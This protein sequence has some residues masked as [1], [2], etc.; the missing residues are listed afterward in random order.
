MTIGRTRLG[1]QCQGHLQTTDATAD[2]L[3]LEVPIP[4][5]HSATVDVW[6]TAVATTGER[7]AEHSVHSVSRDGATATY[8]GE[9]SNGSYSSGAGAWVTTVDCTGTGLRVRVT[10]EAA[11]TIEWHAVASFAP[12][13]VNVPIVWECSATPYDSSMAFTSR[14]SA[15]ST[16]Y[17]DWGDGSFDAVAGTGGDVATAHNYASAGH[18]AIRVSCTSHAAM[19]RLLAQSNQ[20]AGTVPIWSGARWL[21]VYSNRLIGDIPDVSVAA[22]LEYFHTSF[23]SGIVGS[24]PS[25]AGNASLQY[26]QTYSCGLSG[27]IPSLTANVALLYFRVYSNQLTGYTAS[28]IAATCTD[29]QVQNNLL[30]EAAVDQIMADFLVGAAGRPAAGTISLGGS[31]NAPLSAAGLASK[32]AFLA[33]RPGWAI[34]HN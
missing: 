20:I 26:W 29:F 9:V 25:L 13:A 7:Y 34:T 22:S 23:Q 32:A 12:S 24:I 3:L 18:Y 11:H 8:V 17:Y 19:L 21:S 30:T 16:V 6:I 28:T 5:K 33:I 15:G 4:F 31:G 27:T 14:V 2:Q 10:G 1:P